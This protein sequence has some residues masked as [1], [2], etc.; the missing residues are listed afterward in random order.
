MEDTRTITSTMDGVEYEAG[1]HAATLRRYL[2]RE[3]LGLLPP[4]NLD[5]TDDINAL[6]PTVNPENDI[7]DNVE[8]YKF[9]E[10]PLSEDLW[11]MWTEQADKNTMLFRYLFHADPDDHSK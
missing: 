7:L 2:W 10:D 5:A 8:S 9:V 3:H 4:Q 1:Y 6:P 11:K